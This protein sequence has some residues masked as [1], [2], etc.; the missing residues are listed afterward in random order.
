MQPALRTP[1]ISSPAPMARRRYFTFGAAT[2]ML[3]IGLQARPDSS[4]TYWA[5]RTAAEKR[6]VDL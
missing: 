6:G 5:E 3:V 2:A 1:P 4:L